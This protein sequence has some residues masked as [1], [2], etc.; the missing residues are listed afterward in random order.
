[1]INRTMMFVERSFKK[2]KLQI[3]DFKKRG[4][5]KA[6]QISLAS[7]LEGFHIAAQA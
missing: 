4:I 5:V 3:W 2:I 7:L 1:M 6:L